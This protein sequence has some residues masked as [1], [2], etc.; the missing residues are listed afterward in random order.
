ML[1]IWENISQLSIVHLLITFCLVSCFYFSK[2]EIGYI[3]SGIP[4]DYAPIFQLYF[5]D[6][7][8]FSYLY[9]LDTNPQSDVQ[10]L[11][12]LAPLFSVPLHSND[13]V[14]YCTDVCAPICQVLL[15]LAA[16]N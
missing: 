5:L 9:I 4:I 1:N 6:M 10:M 2:D 16:P 14:L 13:S 15:L 3:Q 11:K 7:Q 8:L 12:M